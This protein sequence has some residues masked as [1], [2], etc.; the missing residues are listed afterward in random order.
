M[1]SLPDLLS[2]ARRARDLR[3]EPQASEVSSLADNV[4]RSLRTGDSVS[5]RSD[6]LALGRWAAGVACAL[7]LLSVALGPP[8]EPRPHSP[9]PSSNPLADLAGW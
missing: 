6:W 5:Q 1:K 8:P 9:Q 4:L 3:N 7:A 2:S